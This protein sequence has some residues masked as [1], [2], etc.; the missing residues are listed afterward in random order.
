MDLLSV[1]DSSKACSNRRLLLQQTLKHSCIKL[2][3]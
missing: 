3:L 1:L 2:Q